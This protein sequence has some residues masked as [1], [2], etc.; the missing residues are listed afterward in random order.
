MG[1]GRTAPQ[2][3]LTLLRAGQTTIAC[4]DITNYLGLVKA[5]TGKKLSPANAVLLTSDATNLAAAIG[6]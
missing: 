5:H 6:C 2:A 1:G 3:R 4:A